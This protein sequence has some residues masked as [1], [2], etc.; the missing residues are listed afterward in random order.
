MK[1]LKELLDLVELAVGKLSDTELQVNV[2]QVSQNML[3]LQTLRYDSIGHILLTASSVSGN[4]TFHYMP[5]P[6]ITRDE[7]IADII[8]SAEDLPENKGQQQITAF[9][10]DIYNAVVA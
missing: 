5:P 1:N 4:I 7:G 8:V 9:V 6:F 10:L 2:R 3:E